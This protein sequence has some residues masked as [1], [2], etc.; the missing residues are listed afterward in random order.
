MKYHVLISPKAEAEIEI[1]CQW[2]KQFSLNSATKWLDQMTHA[3]ASLEV[4][5]DRHPLA[6]ETDYFPFKLRQLLVGKKRHA[7]RVLFSVDE[8]TVM[9]HHVRHGAKKF[10]RPGG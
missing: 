5:P 2:I 9:I 6:P 10:L 3:I 8:S 4:H 1:A 7:Y